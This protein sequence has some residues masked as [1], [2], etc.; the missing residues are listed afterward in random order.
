M[1]PSPTSSTTHAPYSRLELRR[2][3]IQLVTGKAATAVLSFVVLL[4][5]VRLLSVKSYGAY[6]SFVATMELLFALAGLGLPWVGARFLPE[7]RMNAP[8]ATTVRLVWSMLA[9][10]TAALA[11]GLSLLWL[12]LTPALAYMG[13][14]QYE[15]AAVLF[16]VVALIEG[17]ARFL[18]GGV[19][20]PLMQ[21]ASV[22][23]SLVLRQTTL[24][25]HL[26]AFWL[27]GT[28]D[29]R[30]VVVSEIIASL[31]G[32]VAASIG[33]MRGLHSLPPASADPAWRPPR[34]F[35]MW[36]VAGNMHGVYLLTLLYSPQC[37]QLFVQRMMGLE[38]A[39]LFGFLRA[40]YGQLSR[41]LPA[42]LLFAIIRPK[43]VAVALSKGDPRLVGQYA[44][45]AGRTSLAALAAAMLVAA[46]IGSELVAVVSGSKFDA[47]GWLMFGMLAAL[48]PF[49]QR[50]LV[51]SVAV[52]CER[53]GLVLRAALSGILMPPLLYLLIKYGAGLWGAIVVMGAG[54]LL[55]NALVLGKLRGEVGLPLDGL[56]MSRLSAA[57][58]AGL[59]IPLALQAAWPT[60]LPPVAQLALA[61]ATAGFVAW[62]WPPFT[63]AEIAL[64]RAR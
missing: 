45:V 1:T 50:Q 35:E 8:A 54:H 58:L 38:A 34:W 42:T 24:L 15:E 59:S 14:A 20:G 7:Y 13:L 56:G 22:R 32:L 30:T 53:S 46:V 41:V 12:A 52:A 36:R 21:Q 61:I 31:V 62:R 11:L 26:T 48:V 57:L 19:L 16:L 43:L 63:R 3:A 33:L 51:E 4:V 37:V 25:A 44:S 49:S 40:L 55:V 18:H 39:A 47:T 6:M 2:N 60:V 5:L 10:Q 29:L 27:S 28:I 23:L 64:L 17:I 9:V